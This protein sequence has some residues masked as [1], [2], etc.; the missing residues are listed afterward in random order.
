MWIDAK[1]TRHR[2]GRVH[3]FDSP[4]FFA[5][6]KSHTLAAP[7]LPL[8]FNEPFL[9]LCLDG[10]ILFLALSLTSQ[11]RHPG[12]DRLIPESR[13]SSPKFEVCK[14]FHRIFYPGMPEPFLP[15]PISHSRLSCTLSRES[16][17]LSRFPSRNR[18]N[19]D[20]TI[21]SHPRNITG[22]VESHVNT[23][24]GPIPLTRRLIATR[25]RPPLAV[26]T[27]LSQCHWGLQLT[28]FGL[29]AELSS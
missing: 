27:S 9:M 28:I 6:N 14:F 13:S 7:P 8:K 17:P 12:G 19:S 15:I 4:A 25:P 29:F 24:H 10:L 23:T 3:E 11:Q 20:K 2:R 5:S 18:G 1:F 22:G 16:P 26:I 21:T